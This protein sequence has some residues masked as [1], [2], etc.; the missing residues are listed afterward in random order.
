MAF[1]IPRATATAFLAAL[2]DGSVSLDKMVD[3]G[4][5]GRVRH[6][7]PIFGEAAA[8]EVNALFESKLLL[9]NQKQG[10]VNFVKQ[11]AGL[12]DRQKLDF[13]AKVNKLDKVLQPEDERAFLEDLAAQK[14]GAA[15]TVDEARAISKGAK[16]ITDLKEQGWDDKAQAWTS[17]ADR[18]KYGTAYEEYQDYVGTLLR[19]ANAPTFKEWSKSPKQWLLTTASATK[20]IVAS[21]D[22]SFFGRQGIKML[23]TNP[24]K[25]GSAFVKSWG[26]IGKE[27]RGIDAMKAIKADV[28][29]RPNAMNGK[30]RNAKI[31]F[32]IE[33]EE[34]FPSSLP[35]KI[36]VF[37]RFYKASEAA[38]NGGA[39][40]LRADYA[41]KMIGL[42]EK[43]GVEM[44]RSGKQ[45]EGIGALVNAMTG[46]GNLT[47]NPGQ[48]DLIN[49]AFFSLRF[50]KSNIDTLTMH[51]LGYAIE[52]GPARDFVRKQAAENL[53]KIAGGM[54]A[55]LFTAD[56]LWPGSVEWDPRSANFG[57][58]KIGNTRFDITGGMGSLVTLAS[59]LVPTSHNGKWSWWT[60]SST[61]QKWTDLHAGKFGQQTAMD[62]VENF[63]EGKLSPA[64]GIVRDVWK[65]E[66]FGGQP[67]TLA[68]AVES[69]VTPIGYQ[70]FQDA[71][72][73]PKAAPLLAVV[74]LD[75]LGIGASTYSGQRKHFH[76]KQVWDLLSS[77]DPKTAAPQQ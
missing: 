27:L 77:D 50:L 51:R 43:S 65:G 66:S 11:T 29:S 71:L 68:S 73:D 69:L 53:F 39:M 45:A 48:A 3:M 22:N 23:F 61:S 9:K 67:V 1:C 46:R 70:S 57:K 52:E 5:P 63:W 35:E 16:L 59:R 30:Y 38:F 60:K 17:E 6:L 42:A 47:L 44:S 33:F 49:A 4:S 28:F 15:V 8:H 2:K 13:I 34:A 21:L 56:Q 7:T 62:V 41:D 75:G 32:G 36:P 12:S 25:W 64:A 31:A 76:Q 19:D 20:G 74:I 24:D 40:R 55:V 37:G 54:G 58:I 18:L 10:I 72:N 26:D 14:L